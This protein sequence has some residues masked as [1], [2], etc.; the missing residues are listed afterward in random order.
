MVTIIGIDVGKDGGLVA[1]DKLTSEVLG[2]ILM[3]MVGDIV[4]GAAVADFIQSY[5]SPVV[6]IEKVSAMPGNGGVSMFNFGRSFGVLLGVVQALRVPHVLISPATWTKEV[7]AGLSKDLDPK[8]RSKI[9]LKRLY[10]NLDLK[11]TPKCKGPHLGMVDGLMICIYG[12]KHCN[13]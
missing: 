2:K 9:I 8:E 10:P 12:V 5:T 3:P 1:M 6:Y 11:K 13:F 4:D 7:H